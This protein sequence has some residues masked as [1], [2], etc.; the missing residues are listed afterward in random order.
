MVERTISASGGSPLG[1]VRLM[2]GMLNLIPTSTQTQRMALSKM[3][4]SNNPAE[5]KEAMDAVR[6]Y[7][8]RIAK[9]EASAGYTNLGGAAGTG[10]Q[11]GDERSEQGKH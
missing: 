1:M 4:T 11:I 7:S 6:K 9:A 2:H 3:L 8:D 5:G 10:M